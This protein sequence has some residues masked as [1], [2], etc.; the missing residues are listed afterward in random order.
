MTILTSNDCSR[1]L[2]GRSQSVFGRRFRGVD[3][4]DDRMGCSRVCT[5]SLLCWLSY[6]PVSISLN[7]A[8]FFLVSRYSARYVWLFWRSFSSLVFEC[9]PCRKIGR[10][11]YVERKVALPTCKSWVCLCVTRFYCRDGIGC[12][13]LTLWVTAMQRVLLS[14]S[15]PP[16]YPC[17][18]RIAT[19][20]FDF[21]E[22]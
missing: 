17:P 12:Y 6:L 16:L 21:Q 18:Y 13:L 20:D 3:V 2:Y 1:D 22:A 14:S 8:K 11:N 10:R 5:R 19:V 9:F 15:W 7:A 4:C